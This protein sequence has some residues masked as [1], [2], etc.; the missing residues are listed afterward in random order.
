LI[1]V[2]GKKVFQCLMPVMRAFVRGCK[3]SCKI[4]SLFAELWWRWIKWRDVVWCV[5]SLCVSS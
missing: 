2:K 5:L 1:D 4:S 3:F